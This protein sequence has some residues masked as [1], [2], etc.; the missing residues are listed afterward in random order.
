MFYYGQPDNSGQL[1]VK[2]NNTKVTGAA[3]LTQEQWT[4]WD[5]DLTGLAG[6]QNVTQLTIGVD[7]GS[8]AGMLYIDDIR[9]YP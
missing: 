9:L 5:I 4:R 7:G 2:I 8:A 6:L 1:Y 3:D